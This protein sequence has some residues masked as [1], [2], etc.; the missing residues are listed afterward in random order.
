MNKNEKIAV[1]FGNEGD[2]IGM[3]MIDK[4]LNPVSI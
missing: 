1:Q 3:P 2:G 4:D